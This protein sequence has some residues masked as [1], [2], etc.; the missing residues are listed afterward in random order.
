MSNLYC[1]SCGFPNSYSLSKPSY[2][3]NCRESLSTS[4][5]ASIVEEKKQSAPIIKTINNPK[6]RTIEVYEEEDSTEII[7]DI[8][9]L[10]FKIEGSEG[11]GS[12]TLT[13]EDAIFSNPKPLQ[14]AES[15]KYRRV[16]RKFAADNFQSI[17]A[18]AKNGTPRAELN[19]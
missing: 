5:F 14:N 1:L 3:G 2:C 7:P 13:L 4:S 18:K 17:M 10:K 15:R 6:R 8:D 12:R 11:D 19:E 16:K 9:E